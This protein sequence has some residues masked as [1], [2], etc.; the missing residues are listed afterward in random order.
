MILEHTKISVRA[1]G[2]LEKQ[3][4]F[5]SLL[6]IIKF[7]SQTAAATH[8][9][10]AMQM[11]HQQQLR[12]AEIRQAEM[13]QADILR[14]QHRFMQVKIANDFHH[15]FHYVKKKLMKWISNFRKENVT[16]K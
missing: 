12:Q 10:I 14:R 7:F 15:R 6:I 11:H 8:E 9:Q 1:T 13:R 5:Y 2:F 3:L 4:Q 16:V